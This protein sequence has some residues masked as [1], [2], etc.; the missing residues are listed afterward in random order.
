MTQ[1]YQQ[2]LVDETTAEKLTINTVQGLYKVCRLPFGV[3]VA[4]AV[5]QR[6]MDTVLAGM[7]QVAVYLDD[8]L[9]ASESIEENERMLSEVLSRLSKSGLTVEDGKREFFKES[10]EFLEHRID[11][12][13]IYPS[14][15]KVVHQASAPKNKKELQA[16]LG[17]INFYNRWHEGQE[18]G[19]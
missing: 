13:G 6:I 19:S 1:A 11:A 8:I 15:A 18:R 9:I 2:L 3:S 7:P 14:K 16:F 12:S 5:F 17:M 4:P 10:L